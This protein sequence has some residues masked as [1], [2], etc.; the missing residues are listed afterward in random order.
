MKAKLEITLED[1]DQVMVTG[2]IKDKILCYGLLETAKE[3]IVAFNQKQE[4]IVSPTTIP[5]IPP[6]VS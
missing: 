5:F 1:N 6:R 2:P 3:V 4:K